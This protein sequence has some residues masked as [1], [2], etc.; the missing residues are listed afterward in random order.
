VT[1]IDLGKEQVE[2]ALAAFE[3]LPSDERAESEQVRWLFGSDEKG[4]LLPAGSCGFYADAGRLYFVDRKHS[5]YIREPGGKWRFGGVCPGWWLVAR[6]GWL[7]CTRGDEILTRREEARDSPWEHWGSFPRLEPGERSGF[8]TIGGDR[9]IAA[10]Y[11]H[12]FCTKPLANPTAPWAREPSASAVWP[13]GIAAT[14]EHLYC[15]DGS[16]LLSRPLR[17]PASPLKRVAHWPSEC[18]FL[19]V[20][21]D[22]LL[23]FGGGPGPVYARPLAAGPAADWAIVGSVHVPRER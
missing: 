13:D 5:L 19:S 18:C 6:D 12:V 3:Q 10:I 16:N 14:S 17:N 23:A 1:T 4:L 15:H 21:G 20:D 8:L 2:A 22:R 11:L 9:L 7:Y